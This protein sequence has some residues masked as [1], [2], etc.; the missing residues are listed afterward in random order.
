M[1]VIL[2]VCVYALARAKCEICV[3]RRE[4]EGGGVGVL[5]RDEAIEG[6]EAER[7]ER[8]GGAGAHVQHRDEH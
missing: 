4:D 7:E 1:F 3:R 8:P 6:E 2:S 5:V